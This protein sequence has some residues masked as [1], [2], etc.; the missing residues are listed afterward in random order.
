ML[1]RVGGIV[2]LVGV[3]AASVVLLP[4]RQYLTGFL[5]WVQSQGTWGAAVLAAM[6]TPVSLLFLPAWILTLG[7]GFAFGFVKGLI[8]VSAGSVVGATAAFLA[9]RT[10][11]RGMIDELVAASPRFRAIDQAVAGQGFKIVL[12][13]R[14]S[15]V[16]PFN[17]LNYAFGLTKVRFRDFV[18]ASWIGMLPASAV[19]VYLGTAVKN[20]ADLAAGKVEGG[21]S[22]KILFFAGLAA[23]VVVT[24][25]VT[26]IAKQALDRAIVSNPAQ[27]AGETTAAASD[28]PLPESPSTA[29]SS[30]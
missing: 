29:Q 24:A 5:D 13:T 16:I 30:C 22:Q 9:G 23:T 28:K 15:P 3:V 25:Y 10:L 27:P 18:L 14:L 8:A 11:A 1:V 20:L 12:L 6:Y 21:V 7:A 2:A 19:Y 4:V 26:R 17:L